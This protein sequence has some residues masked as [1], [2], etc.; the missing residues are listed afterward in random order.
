MLPSDSVLEPL[1]STAEAR[2][3][4]PPDYLRAAGRACDRGLIAPDSY[5]TAAGEIAPPRRTDRKG[6]TQPGSSEGESVALHPA[7]RRN[8]LGRASSSNRSRAHRGLAIDRL[9]PLESGRGRSRY[10]YQCTGAEHLLHV[11]SERIHARNRLLGQS[12]ACREPGKDKP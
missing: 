4:G 11:E 8:P 6:H 3:A 5:A 1:F 10:F 2:R 7:E 12:S 9:A